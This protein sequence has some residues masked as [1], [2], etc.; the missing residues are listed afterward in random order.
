MLGPTQ[1][2]S[3]CGTRHPITSQDL[4]TASSASCIEKLQVLR[5]FLMCHVLCN[6]CQ[7]LPAHSMTSGKPVT[8]SL[9]AA[10][11]STALT[12]AEWFRSSVCVAI[13]D[14]RR[15]P[16]ND[17]PPIQRDLPCFGMLSAVITYHCCFCQPPDIRC[18]CTIAKPTSH[19]LWVE[20]APLA[21]LSSQDPAAVGT[22]VCPVLFTPSQ[23]SSLH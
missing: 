23:V 15:Y 21:S 10:P 13:S 14:G 18:S 12:R 20:R 9:Q 19:M 16:G 8:L 11:S 5:P 7:E 3:A 17:Q 4:V 6:K 22:G 2:G 1:P